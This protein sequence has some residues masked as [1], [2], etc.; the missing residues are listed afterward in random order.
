LS[1][2]RRSAK[3]EQ[4][5]LTEHRLIGL[6]TRAAISPEDIAMGVR[7][8]TGCV[9]SYVARGCG[10]PDLP[11]AVPEGGAFRSWYILSTARNVLISRWDNADVWGSDFA[12]PAEATWIQ[13]VAPTTRT[14]TSSPAMAAVKVRRWRPARI[15]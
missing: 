15:F 13:A 7:F 4:T 3:V 11:E 8:S 5:Y 6:Y 1:L 14:F 2:T 10:G 9:S 12:K